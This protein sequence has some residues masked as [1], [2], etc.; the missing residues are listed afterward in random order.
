MFVG[1]VGENAP[2]PGSIT[3]AVW[4]EFHPWGYKM[5]GANFEGFVSA[6]N[7]SDCVLSFVSQ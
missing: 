7:D 1:K 5:I 4:L 2:D 6:H 3:A